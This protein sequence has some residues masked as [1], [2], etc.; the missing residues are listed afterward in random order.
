MRRKLARLW[1]SRF[2]SGL[3]RRAARANG[4][5][6]V[7]YLRDVLERLPATFDKDVGALLPR[8][9]KLAAGQ[10]GRGPYAGRARGD[11]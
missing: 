6:P 3:P 9:W 4:H 11:V 1:M 10:D 8:A 7:E 2:A 5:H